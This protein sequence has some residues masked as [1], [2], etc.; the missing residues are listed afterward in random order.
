MTAQPGGL[1][2]TRSR[3]PD[4][5]AIAAAQRVLRGAER[6]GEPFATA[7][8]FPAEAYTGEDFWRFERWALFE[9]EWLC[10]GHVNQVP[11]P[12]DVLSITV[13][14]EPLLLTR[15]EAGELNVLSAICQHRGHPLREGLAAP[16][17]PG[18]CGHTKLLICPYHSW[19]Y[20]LD[21]ALNGAPGMNRTAPLAELRA[22]IR[23]PRIRHEVHEGLVFINFDPVAQPLGPSLR[24]MLAMIEGFGLADL[25]PTAS[26]SMPVGSNWKLYQ[27]NALEP[28]H[29]DTVHKTSHNPA[30]ARLSAFY[31]Y[32]PGDGAI[33]T[34]TGFAQSNELYAGNDQV[35]LPA[36]AG[37]SEEQNSR[38]LFIAVLPLLFL[39]FEPG[40]V[41]VT[42]ALP[43]DAG[44]MTLQ[45]FTLYPAAATAVH[46]FA[47]TVV[48]QTA[49]LR[50]ILMEDIVTQEALQRGH[51]SRFTPAGT[52]SW[53]ETTLPQMNQ[54]LAERYRAALGRL[55]ADRLAA[56]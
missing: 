9:H 49:A 25:Q 16:A 50:T 26:M 6:V 2:P 19:S 3:T 23:L 27:E 22:R 39:V 34:T 33:I 53:L 1:T 31:Q 42:L 14:D 37:L 10:V 18:I 46:G 36:I 48:S 56:Q 11:N 35:A 54:W 47:E 17:T 30:P 38:L 7:E 15:D 8:L 5:T 12:G 20:K 4:A 51:R 13:L 24:K 45:T 32:T 41:L 43:H 40:S 55:A 21:G 52:L 29:T 44:S 28:Y